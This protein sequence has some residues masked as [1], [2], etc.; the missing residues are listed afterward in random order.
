MEAKVTVCIP[1]YN[2]GETLRS[3]LHSVR[4]Q[5]FQ[6]WK[7]CIAIEPTGEHQQTQIVCEQMAYE[8]SRIS[9]IVNDKTLGWAGN[10]QALME[11]VQTEFFMVLPHDDGL[12][13]HCIERLFDAHQRNP[14]TLITFPDIYFFGSASGRQ[15]PES[16]TEPLHLRIWNYLISGGNPEFWKGLVR[17]SAVQETKFFPVNGPESFAAE[18]EWALTLLMNGPAVRVPIPLYYKRIHGKEANNVS[19][20]WFYKYGESKLIDSLEEHRLR[21]LALVESSKFSASEQNE[22]GFACELACINRFLAFS[23][24]RIP[25]TK[26][27]EDRLSKLNESLSD[28][29]EEFRQEAESQI[30]FCQGLNAVV[31]E[32][33]DASEALF[34]KS[35]ALNKKNCAAKVNLVKILLRKL[36]THEALSLYT[37]LSEENPAFWQLREIEHW[38]NEHLKN[39]FC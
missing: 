38:I 8:D 5:T 16:R 2:T 37:E 18:Y 29:R 34:R 11:R 14:Q 31:K 27:I 1:A 30:Y 24:E 4:S 7:A 25:F 36:E 26:A 6:D 33:F 17:R 3:I 39:K 28:L 32:V 15:V 12:H 9:F 22:I 19:N 23:L 13:P 21:L 10:I 35:L 20:E